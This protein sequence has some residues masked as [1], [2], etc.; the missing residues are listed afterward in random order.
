MNKAVT[1]GLIGIGG[2]LAWEWWKGHEASGVAPTAGITQVPISNLPGPQNWSLSGLGMIL[3]LPKLFAGV[4][5]GSGFG[6]QEFSAGA[7]YGLRGI[8][9]DPLM[10]AGY[11]DVNPF[12]EA[13]AFNGSQGDSTTQDFYAAAE[14]M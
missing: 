14:G 3:D 5:P 10:S 12:N 4:K 9:D 2:Y 1:Y 13:A 7:K 6:E 11:I 8:I